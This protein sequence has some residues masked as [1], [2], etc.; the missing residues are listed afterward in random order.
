LLDATA[1]DEGDQADGIGAQANQSGCTAVEL[2]VGPR[3]GRRLSG[4]SSAMS[5][6][7][8]TNSAW[9]WSNPAGEPPANHACN[10]SR[11]RLARATARRDPGHSP[12]FGAG[13]STVLVNT[14]VVIV[15]LLAWL[16][17]RE[18]SGPRFVLSCPSS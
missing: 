9:M 12:K 7:R 14:Q 15:P 2:P 4:R 11:S 16:V 1:R 3:D 13:L 8:W 5:H 17:D 10:A 18:R 6:S